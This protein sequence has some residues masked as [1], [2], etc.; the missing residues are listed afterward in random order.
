MTES[1]AS[2]APSPPRPS[3]RSGPVRALGLS[4]VGG[5]LLLVGAACT[6]SIGG[7]INPGEEPEVW[8]AEVTIT[9]LG[10]GSGDVDVSFSNGTVDQ[11]CGTLAPAGECVVD[12]EDGEPI[13]SLFLDAIPEATSTFEGWVG[14]CDN[15]ECAIDLPEE[16]IVRFRLEVIFDQRIGSATVGPARGQP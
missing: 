6:N 2:G 1:R 3:R 13:D 10:D 8:R 14:P 12:V 16:D 9:N 11:P 5:L 7:P 4:A 15:P